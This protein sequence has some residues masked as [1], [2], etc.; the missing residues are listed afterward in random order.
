MRRHT[1][2]IYYFVGTLCLVCS[3]FLLLYSG[4]SPESLS[5]RMIPN[6][7]IYEK[8]DR[9]YRD[10]YSSDLPLHMDSLRQGAVF[11]PVY[12]VTDDSEFLGLLRSFGMEGA[13]VYHEE[14]YSLAKKDGRSLRVYRFLNLL[15][16]ESTLCQAAILWDIGNIEARDIAAA[17][18]R[19]HLFLK[20]PFETEI[21]RNGDLIVVAFYENL[22][23]I[24]NRAFP[25]FITLDNRGNI[26]EVS[27]F[28]FEYEELGRSDIM[29]PRAALADLPRNHEGKIR[30]TDFELAYVFTNSVLQ[31]TYTFIGITEDGSAFSYCV[32]A[33]KSY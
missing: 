21:T 9:G 5:T 22:G 4:F 30:I 19:E 14:E 27:H 25:T 11:V 7:I 24:L 33:L 15:E 32:V 10:F 16:Y 13:C 8:T 29:T 26:R 23:K 2:Y 20:E 31:P 28:Y 12:S 3:A 18:A 17:F 6:R 1:D